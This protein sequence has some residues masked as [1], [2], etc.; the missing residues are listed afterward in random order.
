M[1]D[2]LLIRRAR[3]M[4]RQLTDAECYLWSR[5]RRKTIGHRFRRQAPAGPYIP[6]FLCARCGLVAEADGSQ[7]IEN[8]YDAERDRW[9]AEHGYTVLRF[10]NHEILTDI[11][12]VVET[13]ASHRC[14]PRRK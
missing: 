3:R 1:R 9:L 11:D 6:D 8:P 14:V 4:R 10:S 12:V 5:L 13:I 7:H 2:Q